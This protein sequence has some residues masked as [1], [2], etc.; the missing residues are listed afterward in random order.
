MPRPTGQPEK[1]SRPEPSSEKIKPRPAEKLWEIIRPAAPSAPV[2]MTSS[3]A[4]SGWQKQ[5]AEAIDNVLSEGL[6]DIF[7]KMSVSEQKA[8][9]QKGEETVGKINELLGH[10]RVKINKIIKLIREWLKMIPG[11]NKFFLEQE[12][13]IKADKIIKIKD[14]F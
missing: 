12:T 11:I 13:K 9:K 8:F 4:A 5:R 2:G 6:N 10:T 1:I 3:A 7:L 14:K